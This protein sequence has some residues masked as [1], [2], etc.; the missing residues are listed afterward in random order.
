MN[1]KTGLYMM[2]IGAAVS[3]Y[4]LATDGS[5]YGAGKPLEKLR[6]KVYTSTS[7]PPKNWY[8]SISDAAAVVGAYLYFR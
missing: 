1:K 5:L 7:T 4:D 6:V 8:V 2:V 3:V